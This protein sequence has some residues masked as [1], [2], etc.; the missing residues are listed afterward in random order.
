MTCSTSIMRISLIY[1]EQI[2]GDHGIG[3]LSY[4]MYSNN[5]GLGLIVSSPVPRE[6]SVSL[7]GDR[8]KL[9]FSSWNSPTDQIISWIV[10]F[11]CLVNKGIILLS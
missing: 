1:Y 2:K 6:A 3:N 8:E 9:L 10:C 11:P 4:A 7:N 5:S